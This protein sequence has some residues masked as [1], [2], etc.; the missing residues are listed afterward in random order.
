MDPSSAWLTCTLRNE[1]RLRRTVVELTLAN[2]DA[3]ILFEIMKAVRVD[4]KRAF[5]KNNREAQDEDLPPA[6]RKRCAEKA[7]YY[8]LRTE[9][10]R[11]LGEHLKILMPELAS[12]VQATPFRKAR[13]FREW[14]RRKNRE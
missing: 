3:A 14:Q 6:Q 2:E 10:A 4:S 8:A 9:V 11:R 7:T 1:W 5:D 13:K 12:M